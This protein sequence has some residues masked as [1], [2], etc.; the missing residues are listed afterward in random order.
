MEKKKSPSMARLVIVLFAITAIV[1]LLLG[2][3]NY[4]TADRIAANTKAKTDAAMSA[5]LKADSYEP[6][7]FT[8]STGIVTGVYSA[9]SGGENVGYI[10]Q[11][12][13]NGF[14]GEINMV[15]GIAP[16]M[17]V[18]GISIVKMSETSGLGAN[19][20]KTEFR[21][22]YVGK[23]GTLA[24][25][26]DGGE[27]AALTGATVTSRAVTGGVNAAIAAVSGL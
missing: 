8:D 1:A 10:A 20:S 11:V 15:V 17:T 23:T 6:V 16:D 9:S 19:A 25:T 12:A 2:L 24:V 18:T 21:S 13:P 27:I 14:G 4:I 22:Q 7:E 5:V 26:K 3:I